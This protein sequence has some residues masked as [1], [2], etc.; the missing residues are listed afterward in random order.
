MDLL[1]SLVATA[2][3]VIDN[4]T[5]GA[6]ARMGLSY[7]HM[8]ALN[9]AIVS[10]S[11]TGFGETGP[12]RDHL[13]YGSIIDALAG[14][15]IAN[16]TVGGGPS[17]LVM[18][19][20]DPMAGMHA[21]L[22]TLAALYRART[23]GNGT[24]VECAMLEACLAALPWPVLYGATAG[25]DVPVIGNR[26][27]ERS[28]HD[29]Y[30]CR[31]VDDWLAVAVEDDAQFSA[32][33]AAIGDPDLAAD[34]RFRD[35]PA[36]R[37]NEKDLDTLLGAWAADQDAV[38]AAKGLRDAGVPAQAVAN[39]GEVYQSEALRDRGFFTHFDHAEVG[40]RYLPSVP[41]VTSLSDMAPTTTAPLLGQ[42]TR[43][44]LGGILGYTDEKIDELVRSG[45]T[46]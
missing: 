3:V 36:R 38:T 29:V 24:H 26:D 18:S 16:G 17:D 19:L 12:Y 22:A 31:G 32:L 20:P 11:M 21:A 5:A 15:S 7:E 43:E 45:V 40:P 14:T 25:H 1:R 35:L 46:V 6:L 8:H 42:H 41:W 23:T 4:M 9:P 27:E 37:A 28:P 13:A 34:P 10:V 2:D 30:R 33:A 39:V 44:V